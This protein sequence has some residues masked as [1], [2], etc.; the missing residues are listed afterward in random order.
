MAKRDD[1]GAQTIKLRITN[2]FAHQ[3]MNVGALSFCEECHI[4]QNEY[5]FNNLPKPIFSELYSRVYDQFSV[6]ILSVRDIR[7]KVIPEGLAPP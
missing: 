7:E 1:E 6:S 4:K 3:K 2:T 5:E